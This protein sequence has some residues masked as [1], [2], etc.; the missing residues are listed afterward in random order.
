[1]R[2]R[3]QTQK[4]RADTLRPRAED[5]VVQMAFGDREFGMR[6]F[7]SRAIEIADRDG[8]RTWRDKSEEKERW[9]LARNSLC[10]LLKSHGGSGYCDRWVLDIFEKVVDEH[11]HGRPTAEAMAQKHDGLHLNPIILSPPSTAEPTSTPHP[12]QRCGSETWTDVDYAGCSDCREPAEPCG[13]QVVDNGKPQATPDRPLAMRVLDAFLAQD[14]T[15]FLDLM[16]EIE[17]LETG[18]R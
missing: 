5:A 1:M 18:S 6:R 15:G 13:V 16:V 3:P 9:S 17:K 11:F 14:A 2:T 12:C 8:M 4:Q 10:Q 7:S